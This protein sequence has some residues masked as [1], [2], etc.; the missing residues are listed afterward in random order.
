MIRRLLIPLLGSG[1]LLAASAGSVL[2]KCEGPNPPEF[3]KNVAVSLN[4]GGP[5]AMHAGTL[6]TVTVEVSKSEQPFEAEAVTLT[7]ARVTD[8]TAVRVAAT[9]TPVD[10][11]WTAD[12]N[13]PDGGS[14]TVVAEVVGADGS[15]STV[16]IDTI[17]VFRPPA[18]PPSTTPV[19]PPPVAPGPPVLPI[20]LIIA[21]IAAI[22]AISSQVIRQAD[23]T[24]LR[25]GSGV[26]ATEAGASL[27]GTKAA[28]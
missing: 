28:R 9:A 7:F 23:G 15:E 11:M 19:T 10:G 6:E 25:A 13:L 27:T 4:A 22:A 3:C 16:S 5:G 1:L 8:G 17:Q 12:V 2:A 26:L 14:W 21:S 24:P 18:L 20:A